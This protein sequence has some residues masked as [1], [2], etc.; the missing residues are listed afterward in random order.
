MK[1]IKRLAFVLGMLV[2]VVIG[3][4]DDNKIKEFC[5]DSGISK[6]ISFYETSCD[7]GNF[8][9]CGGLDKLLNMGNLYRDMK[10]SEIICQNYNGSTSDIEIIIDSIKYAKEI[11]KFLAENNVAKTSSV[12]QEMARIVAGEEYL[13]TQLKTF[14]GVQTE[15]IQGACEDIG[16][17]YIWDKQYKKGMQYLKKS[18]DYGGLFACGRL[19]DIY[20][21]NTFYLGNDKELEKFKNLSLAKKYYGRGCDLGHK[22]S[23][24]EYIKLHKK[25]VK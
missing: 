5:G 12:M 25:G 22:V 6:C 1:I 23:C 4:T 24:D 21:G 18:C 7:S 14:E 16:D 20:S 9:A 10:G 2:S 8:M 11:G 17:D 13:Y 3:E 19:G 15:I